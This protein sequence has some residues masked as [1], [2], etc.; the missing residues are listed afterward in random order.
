MA[1]SNRILVKMRPQAAFGAAAASRTNLR[2]LFDTGVPAAGGFG[3]AASPFGLSAEP[4]WF[5]ADLP[6]GGPN[7]WDAAH[8]QVAD[9]LGVAGSDIAMA[10]P[11]LVQSYPD[12]NEIAVPGQPFAAAGNCNPRPQASDSRPPKVLLDRAPRG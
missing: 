11:D 5:L 12:A 8:A 10:E 7:P 6:D 4:Q 1:E 2:P 9:Q 3:L